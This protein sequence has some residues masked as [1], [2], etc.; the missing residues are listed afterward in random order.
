VIEDEGLLDLGGIY[1]DPTWGDPVQ[2]DELRIT[3]VSGEEIV[4]V[5]YNR[6]L[7][8]LFAST[9]ALMAIHRAIGKMVPC[10]NRG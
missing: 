6:A 8:L 2:Y 7:G 3:K 10:A 9:D 5:C 1:G 4:I